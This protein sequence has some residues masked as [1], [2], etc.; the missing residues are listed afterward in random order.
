MVAKVGTK[1][2]VRFKQMYQGSMCDISRRRIFQAKGT[3][4]VDQDIHF[5]LCL[6]NIKEVIVAGKENELRSER[7]ES[8]VTWGLVGHYTLND[9]KT[10]LLEGFERRGD[11]I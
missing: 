4:S 1:E 8:Q 10:Q 3:S 7:F 2:E 9:M 5:P 6:M 11:I